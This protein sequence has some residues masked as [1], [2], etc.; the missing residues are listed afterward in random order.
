M[1][2]AMTEA[3]AVRVIGMIY[4]NPEYKAALLEQWRRDD[5]GARFAVYAAA[6]RR[7]LK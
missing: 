6:R 5:P 1:K 4:T 3:E 7:G 2:P